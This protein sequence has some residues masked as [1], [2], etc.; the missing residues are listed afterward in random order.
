MV[1]VVY[2]IQNYVKS[3]IGDRRWLCFSYVDI[4]ETDPN[5]W[6]LSASVLKLHRWPTTVDLSFFPYF[7]QKLQHT[8]SCSHVPLMMS[9]IASFGRRFL[10][11]PS[12]FSE[13]DLGF[14]TYKLH[15]GFI[16]ALFFITNCRCPLKFDLLLAARSVPWLTFHYHLGW[17]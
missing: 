15:L 1:F 13:N 5:L 2:P 6:K 12:Q 14:F 3:G 7:F 10:Q 16:Y 8:F 4:E 9:N 11:F 17:I